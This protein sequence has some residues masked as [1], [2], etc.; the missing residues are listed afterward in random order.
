MK[1]S[2][3]LEPMSLAL[4]RTVTPLLIELW[5][6][7]CSQVIFSGLIDSL[8]V[9]ASL[10]KTEKLALIVIKKLLKRNLFGIQMYVC[11]ENRRVYKKS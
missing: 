7:I 5:S 11:N 4:W 3:G 8:F 6:Y 2:K 10:H 1:A 9:L